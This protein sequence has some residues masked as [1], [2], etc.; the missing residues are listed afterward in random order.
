MINMIN[1]NK[2]FTLI[3]TIVAITILMISIVGPLALASKGIVYAEYVRDEITAFN[4]AQE[5]MESIRNIR[6]ENI[7]NRLPGGWL[8]DID[9]CLST[10][11]PPVSLCRLD[12]WKSNSL[13]TDLEVFSGSG[14]LDDWLVM[15]TLKVG[16]GKEGILYGY[17]FNPAIIPAPSATNP[18]PVKASLF[19]R[20][21]TIVPV[22]YGVPTVTQEEINANRLSVPGEISITVEVKWRRIPFLPR[23]LT[24]SENLYS[25]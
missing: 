19:S 17:D 11:V 1:K 14:T 9:K 8:L 23:T 24:I 7:S 13:R 5:A 15:N 2:G 22:S 3:E 25:R 18:L 6:D 20:K 16:T 10:A 12:I 21:I 4:L